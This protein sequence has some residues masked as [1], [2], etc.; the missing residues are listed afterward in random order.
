M[1]SSVVIIA[2]G[3]SE[4]VV[5]SVDAVTV[6]SGCV[7]LAIS[8]TSFSVVKS[9]GG[10]VSVN[11]GSV[12]VSVMPSV[13]AGDDAS[14]VVVLTVSSVVIRVSVVACVEVVVVTVDDGVGDVGMVGDVRS[15]VVLPRELVIS[16]V[17]EG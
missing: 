8:V 7:V 6:V 14:S 13:V 5:T 12:S 15:S 9:T 4:S 3:A 1:G 2:V 17:V 10:K 11:D 16:S